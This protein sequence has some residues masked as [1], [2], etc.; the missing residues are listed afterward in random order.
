MYYFPN[1]E[2]VH[3]SVSGFN[4]CFLTCIQIPPNAGKVVWYS[5]LFKNFP[6]FV[7]IHTVKG[8]SIVNEAEVDV[9]LEFLCF[10]VIQW[11]QAIWSLVPVPFLNP[12]WTSGSSWFRYCW[13]LPWRILSITEEGIH[14]AWTP[15]WACSCW[16]CSATFPVDSEL[17]V[18][19][20]VKS[21]SRV[22]LFVTPW[23]VAYQ[24]SQSIGFSRQKYWSGL[25][26]SSPGDLPDPGIEPESPAL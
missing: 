26:L 21:L 23:T 15:S 6:Q 18:W 5:Q 22:R 8:F 14:R 2:P 10:S 20:E 16:S 17:C 11:I 19:S 1:L 4:C 25:P 24:A 7:V 12:A 9:F 13:S 3:S